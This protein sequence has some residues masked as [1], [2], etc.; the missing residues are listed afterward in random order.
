MSRAHLAGLLVAM[1]AAG[2]C[3]KSPTSPTNTTSTTT[4]PAGTTFVE[5]IDVGGVKFYSFTTLA[6]GVVTVMLGSVT[7][8]ATNLP[9]DVAVDV[10]IGVPSGTDCSPQVSQTLTAA[11]VPQLGQ[12]EVPGTYCIRVSDAGQLTGPVRF[13]VRFTHS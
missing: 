10:A 6:E 5:T 11:L 13:V 7:V 1:I 3:S 2:G 12:D 8:P 9:A 4:T